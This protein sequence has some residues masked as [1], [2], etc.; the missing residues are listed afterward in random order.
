MKIII[1]IFIIFNIISNVKG[2][3]YP[4]YTPVFKPSNEP[5][6]V[7][8]LEQTKDQPLLYVPSYSIDT[9]PS[10]LKAIKITPYSDTIITNKAPSYICET[11][12]SNLYTSNELNCGPIGISANYN[13][14]HH[15][16]LD[17]FNDCKFKC[18]I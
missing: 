2:N 6:F 18:Y 14:C 9:T 16:N 7:P 4:T 1:I 10:T 13:R 17:I 3:L 5:S 8:Y 15:K 12:C 11:T